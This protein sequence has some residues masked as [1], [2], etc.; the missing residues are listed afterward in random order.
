KAMKTAHLQ[1]C[2]FVV[3]TLALLAAL[4]GQS[5]NNNNTATN[6]LLLNGTSTSYVTVPSGVWFSGNFTIEGWVYPR[7]F[8]SWERLIDFSDGPG[9]NNVYLAI[10]FG[11]SGYPVLG[12][13]TS[14]GSPTYAAV[15]NVL[16]TNQW[17]H[18]AAT[19]DGTNASIYV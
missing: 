17:S 5:Q 13:F 19:L 16:P 7:S 15:N 1:L 9:T 14:P 12:A 18:L 10:S 2:R 6:A 3:L 11:T 4:P 8:N